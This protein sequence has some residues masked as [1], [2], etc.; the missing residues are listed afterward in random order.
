MNAM[1]MKP[2]PT[3]M[4]QR[5]MGTP[6][7]NSAPGKQ[8]PKMGMAPKMGQGPKMA[9]T[10]NKMSPKKSALMRAIKKG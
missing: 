4:G 1:P 5:M 9:P 7:K 3:P 6:M 10:P 2:K 8:A